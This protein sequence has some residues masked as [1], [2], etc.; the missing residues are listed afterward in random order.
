[1]KITKKDQIIQLYKKG[2]EIESIVKKGFN[3]KYVNQVLKN[4]KAQIPTSPHNKEVNI[5]SANDLKQLASILEDLQS[6]CDN[7]IVNIDISIKVESCTS[8]SND[9][10]IPLLNPI[11]VFRDIGQD[12]LKEQLKLF[13]LEDLMKIIKTY[14]PDLNGKIY[15]Q[16]NI[17]SVIDYIIESVSKLSKVSQVFKTETK[18]E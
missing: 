17:N 13:K 12:R 18:L 9:I 11:T 3:R 15:K 8:S 7:V 10:K 2:L 6:K 1:M 4:I 16:K 14:I 5:N